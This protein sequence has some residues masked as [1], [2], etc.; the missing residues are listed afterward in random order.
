MSIYK[1]SEIGLLE[2]SSNTIE[3]L[4]AHGMKLPPEFVIENTKLLYV[5]V[6]VTQSESKRQAIF[7]LVSDFFPLRSLIAVSERFGAAT[8]QQCTRNADEISCFSYLFYDL[9][10][11]FKS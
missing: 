2:R 5:T 10:M 9:L 8:F 11:F 6:S 4:P 3:N 7:E 1:R